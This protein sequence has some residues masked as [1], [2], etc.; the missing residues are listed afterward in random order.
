M[1]KEHKCLEN[2]KDD[3]PIIHWNKTDAN[4]KK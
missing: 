3:G 2:G 4:T 1:F